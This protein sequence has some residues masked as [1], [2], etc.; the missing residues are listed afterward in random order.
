MDHVVPK[1]EMAAQ[2]GRML[3]QHKPATYK[4]R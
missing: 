3:L 2:I 1:C 4:K